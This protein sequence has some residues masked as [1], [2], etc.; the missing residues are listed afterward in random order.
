[1]GRSPENGKPFDRRET[2]DR[3][4][5]GAQLK[6]DWLATWE[7][8]RKPFASS[9]QPFQLFQSKSFRA[10]WNESTSPEMVLGCGDKGQ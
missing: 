5:I 9:N 6:V 3:M 7:R 10:T 2:F 4:I 8:H 1:M